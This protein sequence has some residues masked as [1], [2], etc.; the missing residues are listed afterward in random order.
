M[1]AACA[2]LAA[3]PARADDCAQADRA[4]ARGQ[5][6]FA[7][8]QFLLAS[9]HFSLVGTLDC[10]RASGSALHAYAASMLELGERA[11][12]LETTRRLVETGEP[13]SVR[14]ARVLRELA[15]PELR[16]VEAPEDRARLELWSGRLDT[17]AF[18]R[19]LAAA[20][21]LTPEAPALLALHRQLVTAPTRSP[22]LAGVLSGVVPGLGQAYVG[23]WQSAAVSLVLNALFLGTTIE[24][25]RQGLPFAGSAAA[26]VFSVTYAGNIINAAESAA[27]FNQAQ[28]REGEA[29]LR[30][31]LFP[32]L[33]P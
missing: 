11:E 28:R 31:Q 12:V 4:H 30:H 16:A 14:R 22:V 18:E 15:L 9:L 7:A 20:P 29:L 1:L 17:P 21:A 24:L 13:A 33:R 6:L 2:L 27:H 10:P 8:G 3:L 32:E 25:Y 5:E 19:A 26:L 23:A